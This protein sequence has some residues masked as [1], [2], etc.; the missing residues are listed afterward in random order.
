M[1]NL[2]S[3]I[4]LIKEF[5]SQMR[6]ELNTFMHN[7]QFQMSNA[8]IFTFLT[9]APAALAIACDGTVDE[10]EM[11]ALE[12]LARSINVAAMVNINLLELFSHAAEPADCMLNEEFNLRVGSELLFL[13]RNI[14][15]YEKNIVQA[16]KVL[17]KFDSQPAAENSMTNSL[18]KLMQ[19][20]VNNN[21]NTNKEEEHRKLSDIYK[22]LGI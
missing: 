18:K 3:E 22:R 20:L 13:A 12:Q 14:K 8:Q 1:N 9:N 21:L 11:S 16:V 10:S 5:F 17:L 19:T 6:N 15:A 2:K 7:R 4:Q